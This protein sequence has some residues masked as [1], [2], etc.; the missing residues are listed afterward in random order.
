MNLQKNFTATDAGRV[1]RLGACGAFLLNWAALAWSAQVAGTVVNLSGPLLAQ[2]GDG[3]VKILSQKSEVEEGDT[4]ISEKG[5]YARIKFVD[6]SEVTLRPN[7][8]F[9]IQNFA[10]DENRPDRDNAI[11]SLIKGGLRSITGLLGKRNKER[12]GL[13]T[14]T[15]TIGIRGTT[16]IARYVAPDEVQE[17]EGQAAYRA[18]SVAWLSAD[19][20][21][22]FGLPATYHDAGTGMAVRPL[23]VKQADSIDGM[24]LAQINP[25][26]GGS[27]APGLYVHVIDGLI[28]L[29]NRGGVQQFAAG[30]FGFTG[31]V[32]QPPVIV[33][34]NPGIQFNPPPAFNASSSGKSSGN[35]DKGNV[36]CEVR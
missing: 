15:A 10:Y 4:L 21:A 11:F 7:T 5:T 28:Q 27:L 25:G 3:S 31:S 13:N 32:V 36:N 12:Y 26:T 22:A 8:Q 33:P 35:S 24:Q 34:N 20:R 19:E 9:K 6:N 17:T 23:P 29:S 14:P 18:A 1:L 30:Q 16:F 2:K